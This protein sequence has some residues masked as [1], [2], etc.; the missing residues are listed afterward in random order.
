MNAKP[1]GQY[2]CL[3]A[4]NRDHH[5]LERPASAARAPCLAVGRPQTPSWTQ[6]A[7]PSCRRCRVSAD[8]SGR[9][10]DKPRLRTARQLAGIHRRHPRGDGIHG[11]RNQTTPHG[12]PRGGPPSSCPAAKARARA[13]GRRYYQ[14][15]RL[16]CC[17]RDTSQAPA[18]A[19]HKA[20]ANTI[21]GISR[22]LISGV[23]APPDFRCGRAA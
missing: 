9:N 13:N 14:S 6:V 1:A 19:L 15:G 22:R 2:S 10:E 5:G 8:N 7:E 16:G 3:L 20:S 12:R 17:G 21:S 23:R 4:N 11:R 18:R